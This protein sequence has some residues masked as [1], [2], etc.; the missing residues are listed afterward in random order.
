MMSD[1][2]TETDPR[3]SGKIYKIYEISRGR[4]PSRRKKKERSRGAGSQKKMLIKMLKIWNV[5]K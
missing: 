1:E 4:G 2:L 3:A 5:Q